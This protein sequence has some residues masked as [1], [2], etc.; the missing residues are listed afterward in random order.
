[1]PGRT[2]GF[3]ILVLAAVAPAASAHGNLVVNELETYAIS[4]F[5][6]QE[7]SFAWEG[8]EIWDVYVGEGYSQV[9]D[10]DGV[11]FK[12]NLAGD[13]TARPT[14]GQVW[15]VTFTFNIGNEAFEKE[16]AH[17]GAE[18]TSDFEEL[19]WQIA[20]GNVFQVRAWVP[21]ADW[22][23]QSVT[24]IVLVSSVDGEAR[25]TA[26][27]GIHDPATGTEIPVEGPATPVFPALGEGRIV[28]SVPLTGPGR[29]LNVSVETLPDGAFEFTIANPL[30]EQ[31]QHA[32]LGPSETAAW[33][34]TPSEWNAN[35]EAGKS[36]TLRVVLSPNA[37]D[38]SLVEP[39]RLDL[40]TDIG[41]RQSYF[42]FIDGGQVT[43]VDNAATAQAGTLGK[44]D[45]EAPAISFAP[46]VAALAVAFG[47]RSA[48]GRRR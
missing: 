20:D 13:G 45:Q 18:V 3:V 28:E 46:L 37:A 35:L 38:G 23:G 10:S 34:V 32:M 27:G 9:H 41:G 39:L 5:E 15:T 47:L 16:I 42:A 14:A 17:D 1:M 25:D 6:G 40:L 21:V 24:D 36:A 33:S 26:P 11:Y 19:E 29:F 2:V 30:K 22:V 7:D 8:W 4:D 31:G 12:V 44:A 43:L 48:T